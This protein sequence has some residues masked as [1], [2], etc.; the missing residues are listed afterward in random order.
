MTEENKFD[1]HTHETYINCPRPRCRARNAPPESEDFKPN[2]WNCGEHLN[3]SPVSVGDVVEVTVF[4][5]HESGAGVGETKDK[6][7][8][9]FIDGVLPEARVKA[10]ITE[11]KE[12]FAW[13]DEIER[14]PMEDEDETEDEEDATS[15]NEED[16]SPALG[17]RENFFG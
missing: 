8:I 10:K 15:E 5:I 4:D 2:C 3:V 9:V 6:G 7:F 12:S 14:L 11:V 1:R 13:A 17:S 16:D